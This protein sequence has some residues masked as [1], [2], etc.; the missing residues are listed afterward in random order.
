[1]TGCELL[2]VA[3]EASG[4]LHGARLVAELRRLV[5]DLETFGLGGEEL[6]AAGLAAVAD[7]SEVAVVGL[8]EVW[9]LLPRIRQVFAALLA[10]VDRRRPRA[11]L[12]I[13]FPDFNLRLAGQLKR[14]GVPVI[15][16]ISPQVWAWRRGRV[17]TIARRVERMLVLFAFE[18]DFY[19]RAGVPAI[20]VGHPL[21]DEVPELPGAWERG[22]QAGEPY[23]LALLPGSRR[24]EVEALLPVML[25]A[26]ALLAARLPLRAAVIKAPAIAR[27][28]I[29]QAAARH[30]VEVEVVTAERF[31][32]I[33]DAHLALCASGTATLEVGLLGTPMVVLYRLA[34]W[35]YLAARLLVRVPNFALVNLVLGRAA[36]PELLQREAS[37]ERVAL[38]AE[39]LLTDAGARQR[40]RGALAELRPRLGARGASARAARQVADLLAA[41]AAA[42]AG[43]AGGRGTHGEAA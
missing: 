40:Q 21:V 13:D 14:R 9:K 35:T 32:A 12:L 7:S 25:E 16:Y 31:A 24:G 41:A 39:R 33:A 23:R 29:E 17:K 15:Y 1:M 38:E 30:G 42:V 18:V 22:R 4:D 3:G 6:R 43:G 10:E 36:V 11:A 20:H 28:A 5:P 34:S 8:T 26:V 19:R 27:A 2:V 37:P